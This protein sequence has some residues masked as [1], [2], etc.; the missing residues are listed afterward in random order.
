MIEL[1]KKFRF[2]TQDCYTL[3]QEYY[4]EEFGLVLPNFE[5]DSRVF[6][7]GNNLF[8]DN[9][10]KVGFKQV[11][12]LQKHDAILFQIAANIPDHVGIY[13]GD[14]YFIHH[15]IH[16]PSRKE[17]YGGDYIDKTVMWLRKV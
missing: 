4:K 16:S 2:G 3:A 7:Q 15:L 11:F 5:R 8:I 13:I 1:G 14:Q 9:F 6:F 17:L 12:D 10:E